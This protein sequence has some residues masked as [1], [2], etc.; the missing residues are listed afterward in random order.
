[1]KKNKFY[2]FIVVLFAGFF[3]A[4]SEDDL[5]SESVITEAQRKENEF[6]RWIKENYVMPY[7]IDFKYRMEDI[8]SDRNYNL[9]PADYTKSVQLAKLVEF[10]CLN[11]YDEVTGGKQFIRDYF[12]KMIH[13]VG[14]PAYKNNGT[15]VLGT[16][17]GGLKITLYNV[18]NI[19]VLNVADLN[20]YY[21]KTIH[22]E[23]AHILHQTRPYP[24][25]YKEISGSEYV[26]DSWSS[27]WGGSDAAAESAALKAGFITPYASSGV[28]EDFVELIA[29]YVT[30]T[31]AYWQSRIKIAGTTGAPIINSKFEIVYNYLLDTWNI[32][33]DILRNTVLEHQNRIGELD[34]DKL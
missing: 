19:N 3:S 15:M 10:L 32:D 24:T 25:A 14:S 23:F 20:Y 13:L 7:N 22:H 18:N 9:I 21:F 34:L 27:A 30:N 16:A 33:L 2:I 1:M 17:E 8:E 28:D 31:E 11:V 4:C 26:K 5:S 12:P 6:D 29:V